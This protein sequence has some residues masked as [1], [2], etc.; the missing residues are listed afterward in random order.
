MSN[1]YPRTVGEQ[2]PGDV[3]ASLHDGMRKLALGLQR[4]QQRV[5]GALVSV[6]D[7][8]KESDTGER[9]TSALQTR[10]VIKRAQAAHSRGN[11][12]MA[13][14]ILE[15]E[16]RSKPDDDKLAIAFWRT[17][18]LLTRAPD[19][20][21]ALLRVIRRRI[22]HGDLED[23]SKLWIELVGVVPAARADAGCLI[24]MIPV[25]AKRDCE[26]AVA[27]LRL[28]LDPETAGLTPGLAARAAD[29]GR[30]LDPRSAVRAARVA[31][32]SPDLADSRRARLEALVEELTREAERA[33]HPPEPGNSR[34]L[35]PVPA[36]Y[37]AAVENFAELMAEEAIEA[38]V[39]H[40]RYSGIKVT[41]AAPLEVTA[42][43]IGLQLSDGRRA[44]LGHPKIQAVAVAE[45]GGLAEQPVVVI[46]L[47]L[48]WR[49]TD[50]GPLRVVR[51]R[52]DRFEAPISPGAD[53]R[54][55]RE[56]VS[57]VLNRSGAVALLD[58]DSIEAGPFPF[59]GDLETY[60]R[61]VL[62]VG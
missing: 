7:R 24:R 10:R 31:L 25:L 52:S 41:E 46:D 57:D 55:M 23:A 45:V 1:G 27:A 38:V 14:R 44:R 22:A 2:A 56:F 42:D 50:G 62:Q 11:A 32:E 12:P 58:P 18:E 43:S 61:C 59:F 16:I 21:D 48:N 51:I 26:Q 5:S 60:Q 54:V 39:P 9:L 30:E 29:M 20:A 4:A 36:P 33:E 34:P 13:F 53:P 8:L 40:T 47:A 35:P 19:A 17:C 28:T 37:A 15:A 49:E 3:R 6:A